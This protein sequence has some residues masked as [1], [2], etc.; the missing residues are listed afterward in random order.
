MFPFDD[1]TMMQGFTRVVEI[2][3][4]TLTQNGLHFVEN[5]NFQGKLK[6]CKFIT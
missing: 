5:T 2:K 3:I 1:V 6:R 4:L